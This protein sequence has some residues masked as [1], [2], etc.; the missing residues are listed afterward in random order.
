MSE[1]CRRDFLRYGLDL[2]MRDT[3]DHAESFFAPVL[4]L[5]VIQPV[6]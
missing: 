5:N 6:F 2:L 1:Q 3:E 4:R